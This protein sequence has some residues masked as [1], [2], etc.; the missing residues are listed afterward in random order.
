LKRW[1]YA[2]GA[3]VL[4]VALVTWLVLRG[5]PLAAETIAARIP[6][7]T[8][9][10]IGEKAFAAMDGSSCHPTRVS[11]AQQEAL[12]RIFARLIEGLNDGHAYH[13][14]LRDCPDLGANALGLPGGTIVFTDHLASLGGSPAGVSGVIAHEIAHVRE[15][16][17]L[18]MLL[19]TLSFA[20]TLPTVLLQS[21]YPREFEEQAD[22]FAVRRMR[23]IGLPPRA[24]A[25][26]LVLI[27]RTR[28]ERPHPITQARLEAVRGAETD[29]D[30]CGYSNVPPDQ[31]IAACSSAIASGKLTGP[32][33]ATALG[34]RGLLEAAYS[35]HEAAVEDLDRALG[36]GSRDPEI[37]NTLAWIMATSPRDAVRNAQR[38]RELAL[39]ACELTR[40]QEPNFIDTLAAANAEAG[41]FNEAMQLQKKA[42]E[43]P[44]FDQR[45]GKEARDRLALYAAGRPYREG[46]R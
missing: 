29:F 20:A 46:P 7:R 37:Y 12:Q 16:H 8:E 18:R 11:R 33:L 40:Y 32:Q 21:G 2:L 27:G 1:P 13:L 42:L 3:V 19:S 44:K 17:G 45:F 4:L 5:L 22:A 30:R 26:M 31:R 14:V 25:D 41:D 24:Y 9:A 23:E 10:T 35:M 28:G 39:T 15:H 34:S 6:A 38:A 43:S 36:S